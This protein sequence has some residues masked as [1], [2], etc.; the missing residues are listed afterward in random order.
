M[1]FLNSKIKGTTILYGRPLPSGYDF[2]R[3]AP[4]P[5]VMI[6]TLTSDH[7]LMK[8]IAQYFPVVRFTILYKDVPSSEF[9]MEF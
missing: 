9:G 2:I 4:S 6:L 3:E 5:P 7:S 8:A 1:N